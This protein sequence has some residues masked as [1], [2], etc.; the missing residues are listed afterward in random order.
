MALYSYGSISRT[1][2]VIDSSTDC[3]P[4]ENPSYHTG[5]SVLPVP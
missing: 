5:F 3:K 2:I 1:S 4:N